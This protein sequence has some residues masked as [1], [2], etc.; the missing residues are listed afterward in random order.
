M[1]L[2]Y[3]SESE[4]EHVERL[5]LARCGESRVDQLQI[6]GCESP[7]DPAGIFTSMIRLACL[8]DCEKTFA[9]SK[10]TQSNLVRRLAMAVC[11]RLQRFSLFAA[12]W[13]V[14]LAER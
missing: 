8:R 14:A 12:G 13:K 6:F 2:I 4:L 9:A 10:E 3:C 5:V 1:D 7:S 11:N